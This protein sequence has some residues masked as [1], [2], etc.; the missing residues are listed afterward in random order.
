MIRKQ[1]DYN[2]AFFFCLYIIKKPH[3]ILNLPTIEAICFAMS[4][5]RSIP[6]IPEKR[7]QRLA[8]KGSVF[9]PLLVY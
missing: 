2:F 6:K 4:W 3:G 5:Y 7:L 8:K 9:A 1:G